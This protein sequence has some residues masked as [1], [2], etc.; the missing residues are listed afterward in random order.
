VTKKKPAK[1]EETED[2][3]V[4]QRRELKPQM[5]VTV[6]QRQAVEIFN[7]GKFVGPEGGML[8]AIVFPSDP[9]HDET[10]PTL[11]AFDPEQPEVYFEEDFSFEDGN[12]SWE[13]RPD[14]CELSSPE[15][16]F[17]DAFMVLVSHEQYHAV[18][19]EPIDEEVEQFKEMRARAG[20][21]LGP[22]ANEKAPKP[23]FFFMIFWEDNDSGLNGWDLVYAENK[24]RAKALWRGEHY[25]KIM[26]V[27]KEGEQA[28][29]MFEVI[30]K[31]REIAKKK[32][33]ADIESGR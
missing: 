5:W 3:Y 7:S 27:V 10:T 33:V 21:G 29:F 16:M 1:I 12:V 22:E 11:R 24:N 4:K 9:G 28:N 15:D 14:P 8:L 6:T 30:D 17:D 31:Y 26:E 13:G 20:E 18:F 19:P 23:K 25:S 2:E 32:G